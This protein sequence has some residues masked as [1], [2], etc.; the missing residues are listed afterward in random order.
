ME[1]LVD[2]DDFGFVCQWNWSARLM[3]GHYYAA[4]AE[5]PRG[6]SNTVLM[7]RAIMGFPES[8]VDHRNHDTLDN[9]RHNLRLATSPQNSWNRVKSSINKSGYK[10]VCW[11]SERSLW[12]AHIKKHGQS[13]KIGRFLTCREA[14]LAYDKHALEMFGEWALTNHNLGLL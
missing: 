4:R 12:V 8:H 14:A 3:S 5:G 2:D 1:A 11:D 7:H 6:N 9:Q 13:R 10:G